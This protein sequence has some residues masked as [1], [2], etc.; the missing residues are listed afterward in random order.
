MGKD[1][2]QR[3]DSESQTCL[4]KA[5]RIRVTSMITFTRA[6]EFLLGIKKLRKE[7]SETF[8]PIIKK[9]LDAHREALKQKNKHEQPLKDAEAFV[10]SEISKYM[11][12]QKR[13][14]EEAEQKRFAEEQEK[15]R[16]R[17]EKAEKLIAKG[18]EDKAQEILDVPIEETYESKIE[19]PDE[20]ETNGLLMRKIWKW[21]IESEEEI[22]RQFLSID[23]AKITKYV[24]FHKE[25]AEIPGIKIY[26]EDV[27]SA[28][29]R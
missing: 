3:L 8:T 16:K 4:I 26:T 13:I 20:L 17:E 15:E 19:V 7:I 23:S 1:E 25:N 12:E 14:R 24:N 27:I 2:L 5:K 18:K 21:K 29:I 22:P 9:A 6:N 11:I 10:K 28:R